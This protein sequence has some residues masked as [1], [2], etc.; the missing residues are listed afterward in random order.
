MLEQYGIY[1]PKTAGVLC[2]CH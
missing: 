1:S 2:R